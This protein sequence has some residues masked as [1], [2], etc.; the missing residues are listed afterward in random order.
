MLQRRLPDEVV[1]AIIRG[2][3]QA[4]RKFIC[5]AATDADWVECPFFLRSKLWDSMDFK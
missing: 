2:A 5:T 1:H 4:E 3:V